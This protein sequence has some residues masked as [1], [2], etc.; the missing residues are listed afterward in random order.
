MEINWTV[1]FDLYVTDGEMEDM[2]NEARNYL[3]IFDRKDAIHEAVRNYLEGQDDNI[4]YNITEEA[5]AQIAAE[6]NKRLTE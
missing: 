3:R 2:V 5:T 4:F 1:E 6:V